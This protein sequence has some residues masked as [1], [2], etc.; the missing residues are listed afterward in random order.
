MSKNKRLIQNIDLFQRLALF[1]DRSTFLKALAQDVLTSFPNETLSDLLNEISTR[2]NSL[3]K[4]WENVDQASSPAANNLRDYANSLA[5]VSI[6]SYFS[7]RE[8]LDEKVHDIKR[9]AS[10]M[11][12][13]LAKAPSQ[14]ANQVKPLQ[15]ALGKIEQN[16]ANF[17]R[18]VAGLS[19]S[20]EPSQAPSETVRTDSK[21]VASKL[22]NIPQD[23]QELLNKILVP[24]GEIVPLKTD[25]ILGPDTQKAIETFKTKY[26]VPGNFSLPEVYQMIRNT[27]ARA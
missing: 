14:L 5:Q 7:N 1:G 10:I 12:S 20:G 19:Y 24:A 16:V 23:I 18:N 22:T 15:D 11:L 4:E 27:A 21:P 26:N 25:G 3:A 13:N 6:P 2:A 9:W 17:Y 8:A